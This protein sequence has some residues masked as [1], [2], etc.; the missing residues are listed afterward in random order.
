MVFNEVTGS[1]QD[2]KDNIGAKDSTR[3]IILVRNNE[4][5]L[6]EENS[7]IVTRDTIGNSWIVGSSTN[8]LVGTNTGTQGG[9]QQVVG[10]SG[11]V[12]TIQRVLNPNNTFREHFRDTTFQDT[13][14]PNTAF[15]DTTNFR[16]A[17]TSSSDKTQAYNT[18]ATSGIV[19]DDLA[20][21][22]SATI[23]AT[24]TKF[25]NDVIKYF[26]SN[27][28]GVNWEEVTLSVPITFRIRGATAIKLKFKV[29]FIGNGA[30]ATYIEDVIISYSVV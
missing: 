20:R 3:D 17:M 5:I 23:N 27:D 2:T 10:S 25:G 7:T 28:D 22:V 26:L 16:L 29:I 18:I 11:R 14:E 12:Q 13:N 8:G 19:F 30:N 24:E 1:L 15:W 6:L 9:G 4:E 21:I